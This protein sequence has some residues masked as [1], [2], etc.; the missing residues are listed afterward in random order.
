MSPTLSDSAR[1]VSLKK[2][3]KQTQ[4][5][6]SSSCFQLLKISLNFPN[7]YSLS[8]S[9]RSSFILGRN[10]EGE[11]GGEEKTGREKRGLCFKDH[12]R[13]NILRHPGFYREILNSIKME[14][15]QR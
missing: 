14:T 2:K 12:Y 3:I 5:K 11:S 7:E 15:L 13:P 8:A 1:F 10:W 4:C 6:P 9:D